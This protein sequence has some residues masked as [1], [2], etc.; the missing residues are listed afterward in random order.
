MQGKKNV[1]LSG[2]EQLKEYVPKKCILKQ[3]DECLNFNFIYRLTHELYSK[4]IGRPSIDPTLFFRMQLIGYLFGIASDRKLCR[5]IEVNLAY[6]WFCKL[7]LKEKVPDHSSLCRIRDRLG[8]QTYQA[9]F[10]KLLEKWYKQG[11]IQ[12]KTLI[13][14]ASIVAAN[15]SLD[16][17]I[18]RKETDPKARQLKLYQQRYHDFRV[19]KKQRKIANQTHVSKSDADASLVSRNSSYSKLCYKVHYTLDNLNRI[20]VD[21]HSTSGAC[22]ECKV[23]PDRVNYILK[24]FGYKVQEW[25]TDKGYGRGPTYSLLKSYKIQAYVPLHKKNMGNGKLNAGEFIYEKE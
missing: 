15:A 23:F 18:P 6:R 2:Y 4:N 7:G 21:C 22:H 8:R 24:N 20:I 13:T 12:G 1:L 10:K 3:I 16:S 17:M 9:I 5:E 19:G 11:L 25:I 14:D